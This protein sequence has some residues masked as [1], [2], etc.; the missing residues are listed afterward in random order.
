MDG[1]QAEYKAFRRAMNASEHA[2]VGKVYKNA[3]KQARATGFFALV[4]AAIGVVTGAGTFDLSTSKGMTTIMIVLVGIGAFLYS[5]YVIRLR[6]RVSSIQRSGEL[7]VVKATVVK[8][9][10]RGNT[11]AMMVGPLMIGLGKGR[12]GLLPEGQSAEIACVQG[13]GAAVSINGNG[14]DQPIK[15]H[16][17]AGLD[18]N[19]AAVPSSY[20]ASSPAQIQNGLPSTGNAS[21]CH[22]CGNPT[23]GLAFCSNCGTRL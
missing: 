8:Y 10:G 18:V 15:I 17:P 21:F 3:Q 7:V 5:G 16:I 13:L 4:F 11:S 2:S 9:R 20:P 23:A 12:E 6:N 14:L 19:A 1:Q 22:S